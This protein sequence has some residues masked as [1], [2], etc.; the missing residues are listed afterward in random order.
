METKKK[1]LLLLMIFV[2]LV[3]SCFAVY[4]CISLFRKSKNVNLF[5]NDSVKVS[6][7]AEIRDVIIN[8]KRARLYVLM[9]ENKTAIDLQED[10][11]IRD[12]EGKDCSFDDLKI[13]QEIE[14]IVDPTVFYDAWIDI[15]TG[16]DYEMNVYF[17]CY[18]LII[19]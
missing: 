16:I 12:R 6:I 18:E 5:N 2:V 10:T 8:E 9:G 13:G 1:R 4:C 17:R 15:E 3:L 11:V 19:N 14:A 7:E